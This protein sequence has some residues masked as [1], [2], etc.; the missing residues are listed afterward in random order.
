MKAKD[1]IPIIE[2]N[3]ELELTVSTV[4]YYERP[5]ERGHK[6]QHPTPVTAYTVDLGKNQ[7][8]L[9]GGSEYKLNV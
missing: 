9:Q 1:L 7:L 6:R 3:P 8:E 4:T 2:R 5:H